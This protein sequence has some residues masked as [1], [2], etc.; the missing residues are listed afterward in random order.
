MGFRW[1]GGAPKN[2]NGWEV[3][4]RM[5]SYAEGVLFRKWWREEGCHA[6]A[7]WLWKNDRACARE[8]KQGN[9]VVIFANRNKKEGN[10]VLFK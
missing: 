6:F 10:K 5:M 7:K 8:D 3:V 9:I 2:K 4:G 1:C